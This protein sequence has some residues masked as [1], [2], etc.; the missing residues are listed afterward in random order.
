MLLPYWHKTHRRIQKARVPL[1]VACDKF[2][3]GFAA[4][5][6]EV[7]LHPPR[8]HGRRDPHPSARLSSVWYAQ[9]MSCLAAA[10][11]LA[12]HSQPSAARAYVSQFQI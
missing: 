12:H 9:E 6:R 7:R 3:V 1:M 2:G 11:E 10:A 5:G 8:S 4:A